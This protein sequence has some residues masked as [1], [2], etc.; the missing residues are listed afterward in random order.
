MF[1]KDWMNKKVITVAEDAPLLDATHLMKDH[2][3]RQVPVVRNQDLTG[4]VTEKDVKEFSPS[5]ASTLDIYEMH[6]V[7]AKTT[8]KEVMSANVVTVSP[9]DP[10]EKAALILR[11]RRFGALPVVDSRSSLVGIITTVDIFDVFVEAMGMRTP[12]SRVS[13]EVEDRPGAIADMTR[14]FKTHGIN[15]ISLATFFLK[16]EDRKLREVVYRLASHDPGAVDRAVEDL[17]QKNFNITSLLNS[18]KLMLLEK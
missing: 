8:V 1:V 6:T 7:L 12:G 11:D 18:D 3:I 16:G 10:I 5:R 14:I 13:V 17:R 15:I 4:I 9:E 2:H